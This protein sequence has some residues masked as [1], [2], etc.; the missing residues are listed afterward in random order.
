MRHDLRS[1]VHS[2]IGYSD[3][4][5]NAH[6]GSL[7]TEQTR[8]VSHVR[9]AAG[10]LRELVDTCIELTRPAD[11]E[12]PEW[13]RITAGSL[14]RRLQSTFLEHEIACALQVEP[15]S[16]ERAVTV[17]LGPLERGLLAAALV[18]TRV[19]ATEC[20]LHVEVDASGRLHLRLEALDAAPTA[21]YVAS[22]DDITSDIDNRAFVRLKLCELL[23]GRQ[24]I[25]MQVSTRLDTVAV[26][27]RAE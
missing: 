2:V 23:L 15:A 26:Q 20:T 5:S 12:T 24:G 8:F 18:V 14:A 19:S 11:G 17:D 25:A 22:L 6:F 27:L 7:S 9:S 13:S 10:Q 4:L 21:T 16:A 1:L 3:L